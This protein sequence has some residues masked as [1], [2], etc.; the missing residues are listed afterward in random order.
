VRLSCQDYKFILD[1]CQYNVYIDP[2]NE[3]PLVPVL[4]RLPKPLAKSLK[5][6][7][8]RNLRTINMELVAAVRYYMTGELTEPV[9]EPEATVSA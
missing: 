3:T 1:K 9:Q 6:R 7:A 2:M 5:A 8:N 4:A